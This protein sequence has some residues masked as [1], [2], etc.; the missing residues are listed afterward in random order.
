MPTPPITEYT[1]AVP[2]EKTCVVYTL[3]FVVPSEEVGCV[4]DA[5]D[6]FMGNSIN[7]VGSSELLDRKLVAHKIG[8]AME[9]LRNR[10][11][12]RS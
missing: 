4:E 6:D 3:E 11:K 7:T 10:K 1:P 5:L 9:I 12:A 2:V 8:R